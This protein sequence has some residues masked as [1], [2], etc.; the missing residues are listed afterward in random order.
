MKKKVMLK[1]KLMRVSI[2]LIA[3]FTATIFFITNTNVNNLVE[4]NISAKLD[5]VSYL[6]MDIIKS[7]YY[8]D[9]NVKSGK[10]FIGENLINDNFEVVDA[11]KEKTDA[12]AAIYVNDESVATNI[13]DG[14]GKRTVGSKLSNEAA[15]SVLNN[16]ITYEGT[17]EILGQKYNVKYVPLKD[18]MGKAIGAWFVGVQK[19]DVGSQDGKIKQMR[20]SIVVISVL[21]GLLGCII[22]MFYSKKYLK[23]IDT[24]KVSFLGSSSNSNKTQQKVLRMSL[25]L[26]GT[27]IVIWFVIQGFTIGNVVNKIVD[28]NVKDK[29]NAASELG[30]MLIEEKYKGDWSIVDD[31]LYKG[32]NSFNGNA[33]IVDT[34]GSITESRSTIFM[35]DTRISTNILQADGTRAIGTKASNE[36]INTVLKEGKEFTGETTDVEKICVARYMPLIDSTGKTIGM[37]FVGIDKKSISDQITDLRKPITQISIMAIIIAFMTFLF[38]SRRMVYDVDNYDIKLSA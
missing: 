23:D 35:N 20:T 30:Y 15:Q 8:G 22:L 17:E 26:I 18:N 38:L 36:V 3:L 34:I 37:W 33:E 24:L 13:V 25:L 1:G 2:L 12:F 16:G 10:L 19:I 5:S 29:L 9:W 14:D 6:G 27:F 31:K 4:N 11:I 32:T 28:S 7:K 21:C